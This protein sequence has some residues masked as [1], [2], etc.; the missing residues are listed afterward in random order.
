[1]TAI[2]LFGIQFSL[3]LLA[4]SLAAVWYV[5]PR[6]DRLPVVVALQ[7]LLWVHV[8]RI[9]GGTILAPGSVGPGFRTTSRR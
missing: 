8:F 1:M 2:V 9:A 4:Y 7:P 5:V 6:L 3:S